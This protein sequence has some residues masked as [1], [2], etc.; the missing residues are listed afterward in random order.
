MNVAKPHD[1]LASKVNLRRLRDQHFHAFRSGKAGVSGR[2]AGNTVSRELPG[3]LALVR[4]WVKFDSEAQIGQRLATWT[5][6][7]EGVLSDRT[8]TTAGSPGA[9]APA[10]GRSREPEPAADRNHPFSVFLLRPPP[11]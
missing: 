7:P 10:F 9:A 11:T 8:A 5:S 2:V 1:V 3:P 6:N 4:V